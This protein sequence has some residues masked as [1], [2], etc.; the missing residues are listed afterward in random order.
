MWLTPSPPNPATLEESSV[1]ADS[2]SVLWECRIAERGC[3]GL[4]TCTCDGVMRCAFDELPT[5]HGGLDDPVVWISVGT[6]VCGVHIPVKRHSGCCAQ[7]SVIASANCAFTAA[8][9]V[10]GLQRR[11]I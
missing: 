9:E 2:L 8:G 11:S 5:A 3:V 6:W 10:R 1:R 7:I 4:S